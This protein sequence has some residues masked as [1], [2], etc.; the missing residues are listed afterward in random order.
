MAQIKP[1]VLLSA[2]IRPFG[3][4]D[5]VCTREMHYDAMRDNAGGGD[6]LFVPRGVSF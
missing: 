4:D 6:S 2:P 5:E 3:V 1:R